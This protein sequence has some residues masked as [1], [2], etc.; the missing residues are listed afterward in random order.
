M[1]QPVTLQT[2]SKPRRAVLLRPACAIQIAAI[3]G[4]WAYVED[5]L[6]LM[7]SA[8]MGSHTLDAQ[9]AASVNRNWTALV[10]MQ[11]L[12]SIHMRLKIVE[13]ALIPLLPDA[14]QVRWAEL[15]KTL[16]KRARERNLAA[17]ASWALSDLYPN[18][19][20]VE[21][22]KGQAMRYTERDL[23]DILNRISSAYIETHDFMQAVLAAQRDGSAR[24]ASH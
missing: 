4:E 18:D 9:G 3:V 15:E 10:T 17:H 23:A 14:L 5:M 11:E 2:S 20:I 6:T 19:L 7:F 21:D 8:S 24:I 16:R 22:E 12:E 1:P 13:K